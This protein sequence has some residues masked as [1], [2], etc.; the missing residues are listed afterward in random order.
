MK[1][2]LTLIT[3]ILIALTSYVLIEKNTKENSKQKDEKKDISSLKKP[4]TNETVITKSTQ[5]TKVAHKVK[6]QN[7]KETFIDP[8]GDTITLDNT[9]N[10]KKIIIGKGL[11]LESIEKL[12]L[13]EE[14]K[15]LLL[16]DMLY[17]EDITQNQT[18]HLSEDQALKLIEKDLEQGIIE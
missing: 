17:Y 15:E 12:N 14:E 1:Y 4:V 13:S 2:I 16:A 10:S 5:E 11:T 3:I 8:D 9:S 6:H 7:K 18:I